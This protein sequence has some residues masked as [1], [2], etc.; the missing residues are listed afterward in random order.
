[1]SLS[2]DAPVLFRSVNLVVS[3]P[4]I[5][6]PLAPSPQN[7]HHPRLSFRPKSDR[8]EAQEHL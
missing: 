7:P 8:L 1:M 6:I 3:L 2:A 4:V 5:V